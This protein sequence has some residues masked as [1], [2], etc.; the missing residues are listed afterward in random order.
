MDRHHLDITNGAAAQLRLDLHKVGIKTAI[1]RG[2]EWHA[3]LGHSRDTVVDAVD[4]QIDRFFAEDRFAVFSRLMD[5][6]VMRG[7]RCADHHSVDLRVGD[8][9]IGGHHRRARL[10]GEC[11][12]RLREIV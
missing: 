7:G 2:H 9:V 12:R 11:F 3:C 6:V 1:E 4:R 8:D 5:D 10:R